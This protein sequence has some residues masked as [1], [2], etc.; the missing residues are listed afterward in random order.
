MRADEPLGNVVDYIDVTWVNNC[1]LK[2]FIGKP[3]VV[4]FNE[5]EITVF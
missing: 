5:Y 4:G 3:A 1:G 2:V